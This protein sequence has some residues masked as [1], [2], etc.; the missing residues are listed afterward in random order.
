M[1]E[2]NGTEWKVS[3]PSP[4]TL[5]IGNTSS[6]GAYIKGGHLEQVKAPKKV[7]FVCCY[8]SRHFL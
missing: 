7:A 8:T 4:F 1:T 3:V 2:L 5:K 6:F